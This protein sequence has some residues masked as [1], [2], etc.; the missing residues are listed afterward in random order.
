[1]KCVALN[2]LERAKI[3]IPKNSKYL[4]G[5]TIVE[6][7]LVVLL[8]AIIAA[9]AIPIGTSSIGRNDFTN[10]V[11]EITSLIKTAQLNT[12]VGKEDSKWGV[13]VTASEVVL[14][15]GETFATRDS[16]FDENFSIPGT[17]AITPR[18]LVFS[19]LTGN[20][21]EATT[22]VVTANNGESKTLSINEVGSIDFN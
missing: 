12:M 14:F 9:T 15:K 11:D 7:L 6:L 16:A 13:A 10:K 19:K 22:I 4:G 3:S 2:Y 18:E 1:M 17:V 8:F 20:P 5:F 21:S